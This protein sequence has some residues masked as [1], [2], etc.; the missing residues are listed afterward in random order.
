MQ[1]LLQMSVV[2]KLFDEDLMCAVFCNVNTLHD[3]VSQHQTIWGIMHILN[4][5][6]AKLLNRKSTNVP[7]KLTNDSVTE[8]VI[9]QIENIL[10]KNI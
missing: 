7:G 10:M 6:G 3:R 1:Q 5:V 4:N 2:H 8:A 9:I